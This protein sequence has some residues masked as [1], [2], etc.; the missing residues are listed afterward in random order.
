MKAQARGVTHKVK[1]LL[2]RTR[3]KLYSLRAFVPGLREHHRLE[4]MVGPLGYWD[5]LQ[6][7]HLRL[8]C[9]NGL[10]PG[11]TLLDIGCG[12]LQGGIAFIRYLNRGGYT[13]IEVATNLRVFLDKNGRQAKIIVVERAPAILGPLPDWMKQY[14]AENL[15]RLGIEVLVNASIDK[16]DGEQVLIHTT[17]AAPDESFDGSFAF[18][19]NRVA[20]FTI[21]SKLGQLTTTY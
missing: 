21:I 12:P 10:K 9:A 20:Q 2:M 16:I 19:L 3:R 18:I 8:L 11:Q 1:R 17:F 14:V 6:R 15:K 5:Q 7:Y 4:A 13:G